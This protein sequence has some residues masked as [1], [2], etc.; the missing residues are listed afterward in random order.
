MPLLVEIR[1]PQNMMTDSERKVDQ[2]SRRLD[3][4]GG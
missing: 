1:G 3:D 4:Q 2:D